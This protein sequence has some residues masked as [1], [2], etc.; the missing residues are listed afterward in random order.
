V[1]DDRQLRSWRSCS[2]ITPMRLILETASLA[3]DRRTGERTETMSEVEDAKN[4]SGRV[5]AIARDIDDQLAAMSREVETAQR[6]LVEEE[7]VVWE[8]R[9]LLQRLTRRS[10]SA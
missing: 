8:R 4:V 6:S 10:R 2:A 5:P 9:G 3:V 7:D 1:L